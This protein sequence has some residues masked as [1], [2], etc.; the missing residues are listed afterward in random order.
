MT[1]E[2]VCPNCGN[3]V[4][5]KFCNQC[6]L[7]LEVALEAVGKTI[8][9]AEPPRPV[10]QGDGPIPATRVKPGGVIGQTQGIAFTDKV[11]G[12]LEQATEELVWQGKPSMVLLVRLVLRYAVLIAIAAALPFDDFGP[13]AAIIQVLLGFFALQM[14]VR[15]LKLRSIKYRISTERIEMSSGF[16]SRSTRT[17]ETHQTK[18]IAIHRPFPISF[19]GAANLEV[20]GKNWFIRMLGVPADHSEA[21]RDALRESGRREA[22]R[23]DLIEWR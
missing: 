8:E 16:F 19:L 1:E 6:G 12:V 17:Y 4:S 11:H 20:R 15:F 5:G 18:D 23:A 7:K 14:V 2:Q 13:N 10:R 21:I 22:A 9:V 3:E